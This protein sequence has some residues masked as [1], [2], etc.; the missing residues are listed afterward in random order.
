VAGYRFGDTPPPKKEKTMRNLIKAGGR[1]SSRRGFT[2]IELLVVIAIIAILA[3]MLLPALAS[4][5]FRAKTISCTSNYKQWGLMAAMYAGEF[6]DFLPGTDMIGGGAQN[7]WDIGGQF[8]PVMGGYGLTAGMWFCPARP[9]EYAAAP[10][11]NLPTKNPIS[12]LVDVTNYMNNL[13]GP[14]SGIYVMNHNYWVVRKALFLGGG[15]TPNPSYNITGTDPD[16]YGWPSK[17]TDNGSKHVP[18]ISDAC[19]SGYGTPVSPLVKDINITTMNNF[20][21]AHK[22]SGHVFNR[23]LNSVNAAYTDGHVES[24]NKSQIKCVY[25]NVGNADWFY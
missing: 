3:A 21:A 14:G 25:D 11:Y 5:K 4:A 2:L 8:V 22:Y 1:R 10:Q 9:E 16:I 6:H 13:V 20:A 24:H 7:I 18:F 17:S 19:L 15:Q 12:T 23:Q